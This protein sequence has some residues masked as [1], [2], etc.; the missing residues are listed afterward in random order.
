ML[1][2]SLYH[3]TRR[4]RK[5]KMSSR[6]LR[7]E[8]ETKQ[9][10]GNVTREEHRDHLPWIAHVMSLLMCFGLFCYSINLYQK[11][12]RRCIE[13]F[14]AYCKSSAPSHLDTVTYLHQH[15]SL[16]PWTKNIKTWGSST[17]YGISPSTKALL[18][19]RFIKRGTNWCN[20]SRLLDYQNWV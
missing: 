10:A 12:E 14:N 16:K 13:R 7:D 3:R 17:R 1:T 11:S 4:G 6:P 8:C 2:A 19:L 15:L 20:V 5:A 9:Q 18:L